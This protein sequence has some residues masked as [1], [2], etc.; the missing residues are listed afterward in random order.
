VKTAIRQNALLEIGVEEIPARFMRN[1][2][3]QLKSLLENGLEKHA[4]AHNGVTVYGT[5]RRLVAF[6]SQL[7]PRSKDRNDVAVGPP[8]KAAKDASG[9]WT[10]AALG[11]AKAQNVSVE[12]LAV[13][14]TP[15]GERYV[16]QRLIKGQKTEAILKE[17]FPAVIASL[18]FP[19]TMIWFSPDVRFARPIRWILA[20]Y[21]SSV[22]RFKIAGVASDRITVG[23]LAL[24][25]QRIS[26]SK[27]E[28]YV[29]IL[30]GRCILVNQDERKK[31]IR[32]EL[33]SISKKL[34]AAAIASDDHIEEVVYLTEYPVSI[35]G[36]FP[37]KYLALPREILISVL[38]KH[39]KFFPLESSKGQLLPSFVG[40]RNGPSESQEQVR[41]GYERVVN[42]RFSDAAFFHEKDAALSFDGLV[43]KLSGVGFHEKLGSMYDKTVRVR[44][45]TKQLADLLR[46]AESVQQNADRVS[47]IA[48]ADLLTQMVGEFPELQG[49]AGRFYTAGK[50][51][52]LVSQAIEQHYWPIT[53][54][55]PLPQS[56]EAALVSIADKIDT[57]A[58]NFSVGLIPT[59][60]A[61]PYGLR[62]AA[63][64][65]IRILLDRKWN[66]SLKELIARAYATLKNVSPAQ[67]GK[68]LNELAEFFKQ[69][70]V[71]LFTQ[72]GYTP[73]EVDAVLG[74]DETL[75]TTL[76]KLQG[77]KS[78]RGRPEFASLSA[79]SKR[80][81]NLLSQAA[82]KQ[83]LVSSESISPDTLPHDAD[84]ALFATLSNV[85]PRV[86]S[87]ASNGDHAGA[88]VLLAS[89]KEP[90]DA[91]FTGVMVMVDDA[92]VRS[93]RLGLLKRVNDVFSPIADFSKLE[94]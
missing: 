13:Q 51:A 46:V 11:F 85:E 44:S 34:K 72:Q 77:L 53:A 17:L 58:A 10:P 88:L 71:T 12:K 55:G 82:G 63:V 5:P 6:V 32:A 68:G 57:L 42:A 73:A 28:K 83:I 89:L 29:S 79:A 4:L 78:V 30:Q 75:V 26:V 69:R 31:Q 81:R 33:D 38:K 27:P 80:I 84:R 62:R 36:S 8:P 3:E 24:G 1:A 39:Q 16:A 20:C 59:G 14:D 94:P 64:G 87:A 37:E 65:V 91:F 45:L 41:E 35:V 61:D 9:A 67:D 23:L 2:L 93:Q 19:K 15:K 43:E 48:K 40:V 66:I 86:R 56:E 74:A 92:A 49:V 47:Y 76:S 50:E 22:I 7:E 60:S 90:I 70:L 21:N 52:P 18:V 25:G 54:D